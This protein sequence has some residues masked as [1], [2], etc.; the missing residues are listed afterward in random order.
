MNSNLPEKRY[1]I[2][3][4]KAEIDELPDDS[5]DIFQRNMFDRYLDRPNENFKNGEYISIDQLCFVEFLSLYYID[6]KQLEISENDSELVVL[7]HELMDLNH[8]ESTF[9]KIIPLID[10]LKRKIEMPTKG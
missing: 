6:A 8:E 9:P 10:V 1:R 3:K 2:F 4:K 7:N 5:T